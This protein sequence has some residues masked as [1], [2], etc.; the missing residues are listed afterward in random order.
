MQWWICPSRYS[1]D[2]RLARK[3]GAF[4][5]AFRKTL[6]AHLPDSV[7]CLWTGPAVVPRRIALTHAREGARRIPH[8]LTLWDNDPINGLAMRDEM[9]LAPLTG[10]D[11]SLPQTVYGY[12]NNPLLQETLSLIP[13][14]TC[15]DYAA[16]P[17]T[18]PKRAG[19]RRSRSSL[20]GRRFPTR[21]AIRDFCEHLNR[22][23]RGT[24]SATLTRTRR[25]A[26]EEAHRYLLKNGEKRWFEELSPW[27]TRL[28]A[29]LEQAPRERARS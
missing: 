15:F 12:L 28:E 11:A 13:L 21:G 27:I 29:A 2:P 16:A 22:A 24:R 19:G 14:S 9:H 20:A 17:V 25:R 10:R 26:L 4:E 1:E 18:I 23:T 5:R 6:A 7:A 8:P 3:F